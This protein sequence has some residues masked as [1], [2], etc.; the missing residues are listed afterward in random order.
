MNRGYLKA[1]FYFLSLE[2]IVLPN[3]QVAHAQY[4][5]PGIGSFI[6][7]FLI[8]GILF[9]VFFF[10]RFKSKILSWFKKKDPKDENKN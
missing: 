9:V 8:G 7:Q 4:M 3:I 5:D 2:F 10:S 1:L 6:F